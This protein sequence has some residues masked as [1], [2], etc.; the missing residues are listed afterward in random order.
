M[1]KTLILDTNILLR[2]VFG[3]KVPMLLAKYQKETDFL[4]PEYCY[5]ELEK[6]AY[7]IGIQK[8]VPAENIR[9]AIERLKCVVD[10]VPV[11][12]YAYK[13]KDAKNRIG[14]RDIDDW[15]IV[16]LALTFQCA[17]WT[18]DHDFFGIGVSTWNSRSIE[19]FLSS[20]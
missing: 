14:E 5:A 6:H 19:I 11:E 12:I 1:A 7:A 20:A 18:E 4:T 16:A 10:A 8:G 17:V 13:E 2:A 9:Q 3:T 15:P